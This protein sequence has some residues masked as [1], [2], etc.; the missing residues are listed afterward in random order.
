MSADDRIAVAEDRSRIYWLLSRFFLEA[1]TAQ[2]LAELG[3]ATQG[4]DSTAELGAAIDE[5]RQGLAAASET[6]LRAEHLRLFG[7]VRE[8]YGPPP[9]YESLH[10][11][12][13][14]FGESTEAV[15]AHYRGNGISLADEGA[16]PEDHLGLELRF[17]ALLCHAESLRWRDG[18]RPGGRRALAAQQ[19]FIEQ[20]LQ[21]WV[22]EYC[23][24]L[25]AEAGSPFYR[26]VA[27]LTATSIALD[28]RQV[29]DLLGELTVAGTEQNVEGGLQ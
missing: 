10:R 9:P 19:A 7:G 28:T 17:L 1:P 14:M 8:G 13:R 6:N 27:E 3:A 16:G 5:L 4:V 24:T 2:F 25:R 26:A 15:M 21:A 29:A 12:G 20:H 18:D 22:P 23:R 11:D